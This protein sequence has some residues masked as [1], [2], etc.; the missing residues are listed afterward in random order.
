MVG[1]HKDGVDV[2]CTDV[3]NVLNV[4]IEAMERDLPAGTKR[5]RISPSAGSGPIASIA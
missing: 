3:S 5:D 2:I 1:V 4:P